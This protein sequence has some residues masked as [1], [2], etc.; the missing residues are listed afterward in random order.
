M[1]LQ[2]YDLVMGNKGLIFLLDRMHGLAARILLLF[3]IWLLFVFLMFVFCLFVCFL[4]KAHLD[5]PGLV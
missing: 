5:M 1:K 4:N 3:L 2:N